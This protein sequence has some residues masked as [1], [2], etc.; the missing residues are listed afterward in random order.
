MVPL[1]VINERSLGRSAA[2]S[3]QTIVGVA[4]SN[5]IQSALTFVQCP[6]SVQRSAI[7]KAHLQIEQSSV[8]QSHILHP[9]NVLPVGGKL[10]GPQLKLWEK[11][12]VSMSF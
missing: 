8:C 6:F 2:G 7:L 12:L 9:G 5:Q 10:P 11:Y 3:N 1:V 4:H